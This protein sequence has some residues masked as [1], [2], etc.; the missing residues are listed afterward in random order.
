MPDPISPNT[1]NHP[2]C[3]AC[4]IALNRTHKGAEC[5]NCALTYTYIA[6]TVVESR[7]RGNSKEHRRSSYQELHALIH[8]HRDGGSNLMP[9]RGDA[10]AK[11][12]KTAVFPWLLS[13]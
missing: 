9:A 5:P 8:F 10:F 11:S 7:R 6:R 12:M 2:A 13:D 1:W 4:G 3:S